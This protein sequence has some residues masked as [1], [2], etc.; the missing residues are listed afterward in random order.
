V[1]LMIPPIVVI[2]ISNA[3]FIRIDLDFYSTS[4]LAL[5][6]IRVNTHL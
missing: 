3:F 5:K 4:N 1:K 2:K 6:I